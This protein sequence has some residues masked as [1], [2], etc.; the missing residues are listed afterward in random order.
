MLKILGEQFR[1]PVKLGIGPHVSIVPGELI[2]CGPTQ[3]CARQGFI[4]VQDDKLR[5]QLLSLPIRRGSGQQ[6]LIPT[7]RA[8]DGGDKLHDGLMRH[9]HGVF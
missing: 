1:K 7:Q 3:S 6:R 2:G 8:C 5:E 9:S 4:R